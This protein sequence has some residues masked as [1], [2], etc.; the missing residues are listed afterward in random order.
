MNKKKIIG[1][2]TVAF[3]TA[4]LVTALLYDVSTAKVDTASKLKL[5][6]SKPDIVDLEYVGYN[7]WNYVMKNQGSFMYDDADEDG[8]GNNAGGEFPRGSATTIVYAA[9]SWLGTLKGGVPVVSETQFATEFQPGRITNSGVAFGD[10]EA[11]DPTSATQQVYL[12]DRSLGGDDYSNWPSDAPHDQFGFPGLIADAQTWVVF[13]DLDIERSQEGATSSPNPGLGIQIT[14]ESFA[15]NAGKLSNVVYI[16][17]TFENKTNVDYADSYLGL[18]MDADVDVSG[19]DLIGSD[20]T[21]GLGY[22]YNADNSDQPYATGFDFFQGPVVSSAE[23]S[24]FLATKNAA[25]KTVL[26]YSS[27]ANRYIPTTLGGDTIWL[28]ATTLNTY[29]NGGDPDNNEQRYNLLKGFETDGQQG[30]GSLNGWY[31]PG[32]PLT[33][34]VG[35]PLIHAAPADQRIL[36]GVGPFTVKAGSIQ[37]V[38]AGVVAGAGVDRLTGVSD[39]FAT[40]EL[41]QATF[42]AGLVAPIPPS[43][44]KI[45]VVGLDGQVKIVWDQSAEFTV[46]KVG[47]ILGITTANGYSADYDSVDFQ[48]YR[49]YKSMTGLPGS[50]TQ[51]AQ[52]D[53]ADGLTV[54]R[55]YSINTAGRLEISEVNVGDDNGLKYSY[56]DNEVVNL[57]T[58]YYSVTA[59][60]AQPYIADENELFHDADLGIDIPKPTGLPISLESAPTANVASVVP[61]KPMADNDNDAA[62]TGVTHSAG[63]SDGVVGFEVVDPS[64]VPD[65]DLIVEFYAIP[66]IV[67]KPIVRGF[68]E[69]IQEGSV[70]YRV[71]NASTNALVQFSNRT[72]NPNTFYDANGDQVFNTD[73]GDVV[74]DESYFAVNRAVQDDDDSDE[75][76]AIAAGVMIKAYGPTD[77]FKSV[78]YV[79]GTQFAAAGV[80]TPWFRGHGWGNADATIGNFLDQEYEELGIG[81]PNNVMTPFHVNYGAPIGGVTPETVRD[82]DIEFSRDSTKWQYIYSTTGGSGTL[83]RYMRVPFSIYD[84]DL[85]DGDATKRQLNAATRN[86]NT[87][88]GNLQ[89]FMLYRGGFLDDPDD[90]GL[91][92]ETRGFIFIDSTTYDLGAKTGHYGTLAGTEALYPLATYFNG[93]NYFGW[94]PMDRA[95]TDAGNAITDGK[96]WVNIARSIIGAG[97]SVGQGTQGLIYRQMPDEGT[98]RVRV[99]HTFAAGDAYTLATT[100]NTVYAGKAKKDRLDNV[101]VVPNPYYGRSNYQSTLFEKQ[102]KFTRLPGSC[103]IKIF[104]VA[105]DLITTLRHNGSSENNRVNASPLNLSSTPA[106]A[107]TGV[108][109]WDLRNTQGEFVASGMYIALVEASGFG[110]KLVKFAVIQE[111]TTINGPDAR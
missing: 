97:T 45:S 103:T 102:I 18:W 4:A 104:N 101:L 23:V 43:S 85:A 26:R 27:D 6:L 99:S 22:V 100:A 107:N 41:A 65:A 74:L 2:L 28:G 31:Y 38:W 108:E 40:D 50:Y 83:R 46:D 7:N 60:D 62:V 52:Y 57:T 24:T 10:L 89:G 13:N 21:L 75:S 95:I 110:K 78:T 80:T 15:F 19:N 39:M 84:V 3:M 69:N 76:W 25:N 56:V 71:R 49:V 12:I 92:P 48:G 53:L 77:Y 109:I 34:P 106:S 30:T 98:L 29:P 82:V 86:R 96:E 70:V 37:E 88:G 55:N 44:P 32:N 16:K 63:V 91:G 111:K 36:H 20:S 35:S 61:M 17:F 14:M 68:F 59:Y 5:R 33:E 64:A 66:A 51:L 11:E 105:G 67:G 47:G 58:Y 9:G 1:V 54:V 90:D 73:S 94:T 72:D 93:H 87:A 79:P 81:S 8:N 42:E